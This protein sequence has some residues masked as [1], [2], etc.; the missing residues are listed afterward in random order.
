V[1]RIMRLALKNL[2][3]YKR[4][5]LLTGLLIV[6][7]VVAVIVDVGLS[8]S[9][10]Q[11][12]TGQITDSVISD[13]QV[14]QK[15]YLASVDNLPLDRLMSPEQYKQVATILSDEPG[16]EAYSPRI[17]FAAMLSNYVQ[18]TGVRLNGVY[19]EQE[20][21]TV[22][23]LNS[24]IK[25][26]IHNDV[27]LMPGEMLLP[28]IVASGMGVK[29]GDTV[30]L[31]ATNKDGSVNGMNFKVAGI[32]ES[33]MGPGGR[34]GYIY[35][36]D[37][38]TL[39][40]MEDKEISEVAVRVKDFNNLAAVAKHLRSLLEP[41]KNTQGKPAFEI[42]TWDQITPFSNIISL[43][44]L[45]AIG[46]KVILIAIVLIAVFNVMIMS[47]YERVR[48]IGTLAAIGTPPGRIMLLFMAEGFG[49]GLVSSVVGVLLGLAALFILNLTGVAITFGS[50][51][52]LF[53]LKP[54]VTAGDLIFTCLLVL[55]ISVLAS[56][57]PAI[58]AARMKPADALRHV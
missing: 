5:S 6:V 47:I 20:D 12:I 11:T 8:D 24:R 49:L 13:L 53:N 50:N 51:N 23:L 2:L 29:P 16:I 17:K 44:N 3:R 18:T 31:V 38:A 22:P 46:I 30:V 10:T 27:L 33:L 19:P 39:L 40:R 48:E 25:D 1:I 36:D 28:E 14:H 42:H 55:A 58:K 21:K 15:G 4:R 54:S 43:V 9:F 52:Q 45:M 26:R 56:L 41:V 37:A 32:V 34:D 7:G 35:I 57:Q